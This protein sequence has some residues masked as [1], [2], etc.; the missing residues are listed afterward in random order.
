MVKIVFYRE[1]SVS[2]V[3]PPHL[4]NGSIGA[5]EKILHK[6]HN[7]LVYK[8]VKLTEWSGVFTN[9]LTQKSLQKM[10]LLNIFVKMSCNNLQI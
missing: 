6:R 2:V 8:D 3:A 1:F 7:T 10:L 4:Y 9:M 5:Q